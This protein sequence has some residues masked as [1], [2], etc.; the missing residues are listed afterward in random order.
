MT[1]LSVDESVPD[2]R[3]ASLLVA[4]VFKTKVVLAKLLYDVSRNEL[5]TELDFSDNS[6]NTLILDTLDPHNKN[7][8]RFLNILDVKFHDNE[9][10]LLDGD[11]SL[12]AKYDISCFLG[13]SG[14][15]ELS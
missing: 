2:E 10:F 13:E 9:M 6:S 1:V 11:L 15:W 5:K 8:L 7:S 14:S 12:L 4:L 3:T